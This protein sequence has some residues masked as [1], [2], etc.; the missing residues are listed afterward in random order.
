MC[1]SDPT[2]HKRSKETHDPCA[3][4]RTAHKRSKETHDPCAYDPTAH[5]RSKETHDPCAS[6]R[7]AHKRSKETHDPCA[8]DPTAHK[9]SKE[10][11]D[12][13]ASDP[14]DIVDPDLMW[15]QSRGPRSV[16]RE[17]APEVVVRRR[18]REKDEHVHRYVYLLDRQYDSRWSFFQRV[19]PHMSYDTV[20]GSFSL[21]AQRGRLSTPRLRNRSKLVSEYVITIAV[22]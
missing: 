2:A 3:S 7:M 1:A 22:T 17:L 4:D 6:D 13:C 21:D 14:G 18:I 10:T 19:P 20:R 5:K 16:Q 12:P 8:S 11:H 9:R 15:W